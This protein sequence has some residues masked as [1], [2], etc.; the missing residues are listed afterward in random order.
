MDV[1]KII[2]AVDDQWGIAKDGRIPWHDKK[3][4]AFFRAK[5]TGSG[6]NAIVMG[7]KTMESMP[8]F[9]L[10][11]RENLVLS[12]KEGPYR[13][14]ASL[15]E[16][17]LICSERGFDETWVI[18][19]ATVYSETLK[20]GIVDEVFISRVSGDYGCDQFF[21]RQALEDNYSFKDMVCIEGLVVERWL[22]KGL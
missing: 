12:S 20:S 5:T 18:G 17:S 15:S 22:K 9:P 1:F 11:N 10:P 8:K 3:D 2:V 6:K 4:M 19:G 16:A 7:R 21:D 14:V 13:R